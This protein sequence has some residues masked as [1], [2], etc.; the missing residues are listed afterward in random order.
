M[1]FSLTVYDLRKLAF[2]I[3]EMNK[4]Q[5]RYNNEK[6]IA[7][8]KRCYRF[9]ARHPEIEPQLLT[10]DLYCRFDILDRIVGEKRLT[11]NI[12]FNS[13]R[14]GLSAIHKPQKI[15]VMKNLKKRLQF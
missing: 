9:L 15:L 10:K 3:A 11:A 5:H 12:I 4:M 6:E 13:D 8:K 2:Q 1:F 7:L 14:T